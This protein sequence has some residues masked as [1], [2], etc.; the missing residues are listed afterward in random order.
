MHKTCSTDFFS[1]A[2]WCE[3]DHSVCH[4]GGADG[5]G[6]CYRLQNMKKLQEE[7]IELRAPTEYTFRTL[8]CLH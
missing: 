7:H 5:P 3:G 6:V 8:L 4:P 1:F 2:V